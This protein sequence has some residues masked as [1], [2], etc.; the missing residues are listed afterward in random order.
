[1]VDN[2]R[3]AGATVLV[4]GG[5]SGLGAAVV[6]AVAA[7][8]GKPVVLDVR[9]PAAGTDW[10]EVDLSDG[11]AAERTVTDVVERLGGLDAVVTC[12]GID[13][14]GPLERIDGSDWVRV[15]AVNLLGS[16]A[17]ARAAMPA[18][19]AGRGRVV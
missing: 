13:A 2:E 6:T 1:M 12:A 14:C 8:G 7:A 17:V 10:A 11:R 15:A 3:L 9:A 19:V 4:T 16:A 18:L 5:A